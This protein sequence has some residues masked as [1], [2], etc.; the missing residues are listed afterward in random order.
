M[1]KPHLFCL[2]FQVDSQH[3]YLIEAQFEKVCIFRSTLEY[4]HGFSVKHL[5]YD[6]HFG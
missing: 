3:C 6:D 2:F 5:A 1:T 4:L